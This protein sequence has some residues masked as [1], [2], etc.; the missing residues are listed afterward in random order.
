MATAQVVRRNHSKASTGII[1]TSLYIQVE[2]L[3]VVSGLA[4]KAFEYRPDCNEAARAVRSLSK[5]IEKI[6]RLVKNPRL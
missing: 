1:H 3:T 5:P 4:S 6:P 2:L